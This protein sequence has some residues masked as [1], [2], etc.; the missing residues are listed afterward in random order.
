MCELMFK[1]VF[2]CVCGNLHA[3]HAFSIGL[4]HANILNGERFFRQEA[5]RVYI[6]VQV[7]VL[8]RCVSC[9]T[10]SIICLGDLTNCFAQKHICGWWCMGPG[11]RVLTD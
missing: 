10:E 11:G 8:L 6:C 5:M 2:L 9:L 3:T 1:T 7:K 4:Q